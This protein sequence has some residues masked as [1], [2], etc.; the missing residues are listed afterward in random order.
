MAMHYG[1][2]EGLNW[3]QLR[4]DLGTLTVLQTEKMSLLNFLCRRTLQV[5][6]YLLTT[7]IIYL[8]L[9]ITLTAKS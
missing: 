9:L 7:P 3:V 2:E 8:L 4:A 5:Y 6:L 1:F